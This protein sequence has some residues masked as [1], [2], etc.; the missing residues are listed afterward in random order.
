MVPGYQILLDVKGGYA[1]FTLSLV[2]Q[3]SPVKVVRGP[4]DSIWVIDDGDFLAS[5]IT[6]ASTRGKVF[7]IESVNT[8]F[9]NTME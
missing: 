6:E 3:V 7:R 4:T 8:Q 1:P 5:N 9:V 2:G